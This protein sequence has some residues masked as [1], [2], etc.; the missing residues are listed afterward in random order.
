MSNEFVFQVDSELVN[1]VYSSHDN[2]LIEYSSKKEKSNQEY[3]ALYFS[4]NNIYF[5][6]TEEVFNKAIVEGNRFEWY[7][8]RFEKA[9]KHVF[10]RDVHKQWYLTGINSK[11]NNSRGIFEFLKQVTEGYMVITVGSSSGGYAAVLFGQLLNAR[12]IY[13]FNGQFEV[14]SL[15]ESSS[16]NVDP[17]LFRNQNNPV[18]REY[19]DIKKF[20]KDPS[21]INYFRSN[22]SDWDVEQHDHIKDLGINTFSF[23]TDHHGIPFAKTALPKLLNMKIQNLK[24]FKNKPMH[25]LIFSLRVGGFTQ[26]SKAVLSILKK[27]LK[28]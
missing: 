18:L 11:I 25:P 17:I 13:T 27:M 21:N 4:S 22:K 10:I 19:Y 20:I 26:T 1:S 14:D 2:F 8:T 16:E 12:H 3:C 9:T 24:K 23:N 15:L 6:N 7:G 5:P 28:L